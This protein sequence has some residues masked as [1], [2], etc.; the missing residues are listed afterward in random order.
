MQSRPWTK[1]DSSKIQWL[2][3]RHLCV[4]KSRPCKLE[5]NIFYVCLCQCCY[6]TLSRWCNS[7]NMSEFCL[8]ILS[9]L[10]FW[11]L[12]S[13]IC[14]GIHIPWRRSL[15][16]ALR[17]F[18]DS[19][20][21]GKPSWHP[22]LFHEFTCFLVDHQMLLNY[23]GLTNTVVTLKAC[24]INYSSCTANPKSLLSDRQSYNDKHWV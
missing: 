5:N 2:V 14:T 22:R 19:S 13:L 21:A 15:S 11:L 9:P 17:C 8:V 24:S 23:T 6:E 12:L 18:W 20:S 10:E 4:G 1:T 7:W 16:E 3:L